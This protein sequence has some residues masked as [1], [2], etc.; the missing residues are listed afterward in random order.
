MFTS[1]SSR[2]CPQA[3]RLSSAPEIAPVEPGD[4]LKCAAH[5]AAAR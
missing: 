3:A 5:E 4:S 2:S 1:Q